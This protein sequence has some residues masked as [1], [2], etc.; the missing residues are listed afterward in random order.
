MGK[1]FPEAYPHN[2]QKLAE[3]MVD[4]LHAAG[5]NFANYD[6]D[7]DGYAEPVMLIHAG[8]GTEA[9]VPQS[10]SGHILGVCPLP[11]LRRRHY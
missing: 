3:E 9:S 11:Y 10:T 4:A 8:T 6:N 1:L 5:V 2:C 7:H